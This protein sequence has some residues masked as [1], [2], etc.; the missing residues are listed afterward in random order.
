MWWQP[1]IAQPANFDASLAQLPENESPI[2]RVR[3]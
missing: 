2:V 1:T 3:R